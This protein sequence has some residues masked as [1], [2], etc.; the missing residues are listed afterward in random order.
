[1]NLEP[2]PYSLQNGNTLYCFPS[3]SLPLVKLD[4]TFEAGPIYQTKLLTASMTN[5]LLFMASKD[6]SSQ[7]VAE[8]MDYRG[9]IIDRDIDS[10]VSN[11][12]I[13][14]LNKYLPELL[15]LLDE[16]L[17]KPSFSK[18]DFDVALQKKRQ[19]YLVGQQKTLYVASRLFYQSIYGPQHAMGT[20]AELKDFDALQLSDIESFCDQ[21]YDIA[22]AHIVISGDYSESDLALINQLWGCDESKKEQ[23]IAG[24]PVLE[25][26]KPTQVQMSIK[27]EGGPQA[28]LRIGRLLPMKWDSME[29]A[30]FQVLS[31]VLGGYFGARLMSNIREDKGYTYG[32]Y[33]RTRIVRDSLSFCITTDV[34]TQYCEDAILEIK[35]E[36]QRLCNELVPEE[37]LDLVRHVMEGDYIRSIDGIFECSERYRQMSANHL[38]EQFRLNY[39]EAVRSVSSAQLQQVAQ[40][41]ISPEMLTYVVVK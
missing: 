25:A 8:F 38:S 26:P 12:S 4:F 28:T 36:L 20:Y 2:I 11:F 13:Y 14:T 17:R 1:M 27:E 41:Y 6:K 37:E 33:S 18:A 22:H 21:F 32:I 23:K 3:K 30:Y 39:L 19:Q 15:P 5:T 24:M 9:I 29:Y 31:T 34:G 7:E 35:K 16:L 10:C 40:K